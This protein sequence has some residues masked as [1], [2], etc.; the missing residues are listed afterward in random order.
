MRF[1]IIQPAPV[2]V[3][4]ALTTASA[5]GSPSLEPE[6]RAPQQVDD[7]AQDQFEV[8]TSR[9][10]YS[11][12]PDASTSIQHRVSV[13]AVI[14]NVSGSYL[15]DVLVRMTAYN[16]AGAELDHASDE[17]IKT[18]VAPGEQ[19][20]VFSTIYD[21]SLILTDRVAAL[22]FGDT[23]SAG[24][25]PYLPDPPL[26][27]LEE[28]VDSSRILQFGEITNQTDVSWEARCE[29]CTAVYL[30]GIG[31]VGELITDYYSSSLGMAPTG[32]LPPGGT[33]PFRGWIERLPG[34]EIQHFFVVKPMPPG[35]HATQWEVS[36][37]TGGPLEDFGFPAYGIDADVTNRSEVDSVPDIWLTVY[38]EDDQWIGWT[39][40]FSFDPVGPGETHEC[41]D[42]WL[43]N[44]NIHLGDVGD[45][46]SVKAHVAGTGAS[47]IGPPT[48]TPTRS[49]TP[50]MTPTPRPT[51]TP[52]PDSWSSIL[53][54]SALK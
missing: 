9:W 20:V 33:L 5:M 49:P 37:L 13:I 38:N 23:S 25:Y 42:E 17:P 7:V 35:E 11:F 15:K 19:T 50:S 8:V 51:G 3:L 10:V 18:S 24:E 32:N 48:P 39:S 36:N 29:Q 34:L 46:V 41:R 12:D 4:I 27:Y 52:F 26:D 53:L 54:P 1:T 22:A 44:S 21:P 31:T 30:V 6:S 40:C 47:S 2:L 28:M 45:I 43:S 14:E 16:A